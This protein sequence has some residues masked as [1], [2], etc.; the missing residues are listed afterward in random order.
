[1]NGFIAREILRKG[2]LLGIY[3]MT[4][5]AAFATNIRNLSEKDMIA[6][7]RSLVHITVILSVSTPTLS[8]TFF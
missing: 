5:N 6:R 7:T 2:F 4:T 3:D 1:M 8:I